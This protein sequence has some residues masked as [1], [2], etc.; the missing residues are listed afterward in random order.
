MA[1]NIRNNVHGI[2]TAVRRFANTGKL[3][4]PSVYLF[5]EV[6]DDLLL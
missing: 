1:T 3:I 2:T 6:P 5:W 4:V